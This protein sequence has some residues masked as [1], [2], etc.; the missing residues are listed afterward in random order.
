[1]VKYEFQRKREFYFHKKLKLLKSKFKEWVSINHCKVEKKLSQLEP[2]LFGF[3]VQREDH[4]LSDSDA[5]LK[6][7]M[8]IELLERLNKEDML[9]S[10]KAKN[11]WQQNG[12]KNTN[13][14]IV[15]LMREPGQTISMKFMLMAKQLPMIRI[16]GLTLKIFLLPFIVMGV[17][18]SRI[19]G[20]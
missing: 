17:L 19:L 12:D 15:W 5:C 3:E 14:F 6:H 1:M 10:K 8:N 2:L 11:L 16:F 9:W 13:F 7:V 18:T 20:A 4:P